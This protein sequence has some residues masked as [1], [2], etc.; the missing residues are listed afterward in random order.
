MMLTA[1]R[2]DFRIRR[3]MK[4]LIHGALFAALMSSALAAQQSTQSSTFDELGG[5]SENDRANAGEGFW[6]QYRGPFADGH[7]SAKADPPTKWSETEN[8]AWRLDITGKAWSSPIVWGDT[9][10]LTNST[11][12]G[13]KMSVIACNRKSG[14]VIYDKTLFVNDRTQ[15]DF[16]E[17]NSHA[18]PTP[19]ADREHV[20]VSFGAYGTA[21]IRHA[22]GEIVW[23]RNDLPCNHY[24]G[25]GSSPILYRDLL[26]FHM[27]G[28]DYQYVI[29]LN[30]QTGETVW[31]TDRNVNYGTDDGD[32]KKAFATPQ[33]IRSPSGSLEL[34]S[35]TSKAVLAYNPENGKEI[36]RVTY[37]EFSSAT[38]PVCDGESIL[39]SSGFSKAKLLSIRLGGNGDVTK[40]HLTWSAAKAIGSKPSLLLFGASVCSLDDRG[41]LS[42]MDRKSGELQWQSR[43]GGD[44]SASPIIA[45]DRIYC[46]DEAGKGHVVSTTGE[47]LSVN[48]LE[49]GCLASPVAI[50]NDLIV[51]TR[52]RLY[53]LRNAE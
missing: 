12:N 10:W 11:D 53:C 5:W 31:K 51:R 36:W 28:H 34:I 49:A 27:D 40:S 1:N 35:P 45:K 19:V 24:R 22:D 26:I 20:Y 14:Q 3:A 15:P 23:K 39:L 41:I 48:T 44:F 2:S 6:P 4:Q 42:S 17:F 33:I 32:V 9:I 46:F 50:G 37:D 30:K 21:A 7:A 52:T 38:R 8:V 25:S 47:V 43:L 18:S 16:H 13:L 29:A